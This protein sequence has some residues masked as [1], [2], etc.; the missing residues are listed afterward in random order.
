MSLWPVSDYT[1]RE[2]MTVYYRNLKAGMGRGEALRQVGSTCLS[3]ILNSIL[4]TGPTSSS[5]ASG[6]TS[7]ENAS[8]RHRDTG[9]RAYVST[10]R[11]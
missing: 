10:T 11:G 2:L 4:S 3:T 9:A 7:T 8:P 5:P 6:P 1:T